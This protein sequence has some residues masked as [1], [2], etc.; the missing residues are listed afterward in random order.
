MVKAEA[1]VFTATAKGCFQFM[2]SKVPLSGFSMFCGSNSFIN[3]C[4]RGV[5]KTKKEKTIIEL[6]VKREERAE[7]GL[8]AI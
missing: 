5:S 1:S 2:L 6:K 3:R 4:K 8:R 7:V